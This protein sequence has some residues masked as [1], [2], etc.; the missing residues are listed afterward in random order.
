LF[1]KTGRVDERR[2]KCGA[3]GKRRGAVQINRESWGGKK[4]G[5]CTVTGG[6]TI[7]DAGGEREGNKCGALP[8]KVGLTLRVKQRAGG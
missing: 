6:P 1:V 4:G 2:S 7:L 5:G 3:E 8:G